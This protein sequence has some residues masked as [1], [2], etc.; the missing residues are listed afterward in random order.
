GMSIWRVLRTPLLAVMLL[1]VALSLVGDT[2]LVTLIRSLSA[3][4]PQ[5]NS[6]SELW[7]KQRG[8]GVEYVLVS[9]SP[10]PGGA[11][12]E[13]VTFFLPA[14]IGGPRIHAPRAELS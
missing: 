3:N 2:A 4:L 6:G 9:S 14:E 11:L 10:H 8:G 5:A 13:D 7:L 12:L 1:G